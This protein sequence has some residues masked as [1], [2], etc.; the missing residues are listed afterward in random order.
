MAK[1]LQKGER[2]QRYCLP[3]LVAKGLEKKAV[4]DYLILHPN[5]GHRRQAYMMIDADIVAVRPFSIY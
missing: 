3:R 2:V 4:C 1:P 5:E